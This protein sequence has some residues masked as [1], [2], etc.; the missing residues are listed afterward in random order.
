MSGKLFPP[1]NG[2]PLARADEASS[3]PTKVVGDPIEAVPLKE[4]ELIDVSGRFDSMIVGFVPIEIFSQAGTISRSTVL[5]TPFPVVP[6]SLIEV[7]W[8]SSR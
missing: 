7:I 4:D 5:T 1:P 8:L 3:S 6:T 2:R